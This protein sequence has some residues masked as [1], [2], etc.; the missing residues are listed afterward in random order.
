M[1]R[2]KKDRHPEMK[3]WE[4]GR[5]LDVPGPRTAAEVLD[6]LLSRI[7]NGRRTTYTRDEVVDL[8]LDLRE[9]LMR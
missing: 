7:P 3:E 9:E 5:H 2:R 8:I 4:D 6:E 1:R